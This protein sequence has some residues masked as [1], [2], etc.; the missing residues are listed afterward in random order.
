[1]GKKLFFDVVNSVKGGCGKSTFSV[2]LAA[3]YAMRGDKASIIDLDLCGS[4]LKDSYG[5]Y[6]DLSACKYIE[7]YLLDVQA[8][9]ESAVLKVGIDGSSDRYDVNMI[10]V[11]KRLGNEGDELELDLF[12]DAI[13]RLINGIYDEAEEEEGK[14]NE[15]H[16][17]FD[18]PPGYEKYAERVVSWLLMGTYS[19]LDVAGYEDYHVNL[20][21]ISSLS[22]AHM[23][24]NVGYFDAFFD[25]PFSSKTYSGRLKDK[26][27]VY[28][29]LNDV[30][31]VG[32]D[33]NISVLLDGF[34]NRYVSDLKVKIGQYNAG[35]G[36]K[37]ASLIAHMP[38]LACEDFG[39]IPGKGMTKVRMEP[40]SIIN[41]ITL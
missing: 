17:I 23:N 21:M 38:Y 1:M 30:T 37:E 26:L 24:A 10:M 11:N 25:A 5:I 14:D 35:V 18:M 8:L 40:L 32:E 27:T 41:N 28:P 7:N 15:I 3:K 33:I 13:F 2:L 20:F 22:L 4:S 16:I 34:S 19:R 29:I 6:M 36:V 9:V 12:E 31:G 39:D